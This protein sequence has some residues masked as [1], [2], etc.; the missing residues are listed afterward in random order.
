MSNTQIKLTRDEVFKAIKEYVKRE[1]PSIEKVD[2]T[3]VNV[4]YG[5]ISGATIFCELSKK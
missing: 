5:I 3:R 2:N 4:E 1:Y